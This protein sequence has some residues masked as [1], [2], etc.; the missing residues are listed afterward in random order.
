MRKDAGL[1]VTDRINISF[2][3]SEKLVNSVN[4]FREYIANEILADK[5]TDNIPGGYK[6]DWEI[7]DYKCR[8]SIKKA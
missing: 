8:I 4:S 5:F 1:E 6:E 7:G 2:T 3:G